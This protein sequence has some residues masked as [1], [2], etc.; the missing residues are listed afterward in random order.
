MIFCI[1]IPFLCP[2]NEEVITILSKKELRSRGIIQHDDFVLNAIPKCGTHLIMTCIYFMINKQVDEGFDYVQEAQYT[3]ER[4]ACYLAFL[5]SLKNLPYIHK[6]HVPYFPAMEETLEQA[7]MKALFFIRDPRDAIVSLVFYMEKMSGNQRD[8]MFINSSL[9]DGLSLNKKINAVMTGS[10]CT[11]YLDLY[12]KSLIGWTRSSCSLT[13]KFEDLIG[14]RGGGTLEK[15]LQVIEQISNYLN[16]KLSDEE[17]M[18]IA[19][20]TNSFAIPKIQNS[21][22]SK[23]VQGQIG[24]WTAFF[25]ESN[26]NLFKKLFGK[27][28]IEL[29]YEKDNEW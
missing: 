10:C 26:K 23:Y 27:E 9:Y 3:K 13:T 18:A 19:E 7:K 15:Q 22:N 25:N 1:F 24:N 5:N 29:G 14:P 21:L 20:Y 6:T 8:F 11:N 2:A 28:L 16:I 12:Y 17:K 4:A